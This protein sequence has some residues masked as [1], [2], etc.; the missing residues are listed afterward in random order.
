MYNLYRDKRNH[1]A[2]SSV[3]SSPTLCITITK[4]IRWMHTNWSI[5]HC[6]VLNWRMTYWNKLTGVLHLMMS[7]CCTWKRCHCC[8]LTRSHHCCPPPHPCHHPHHCP[9]RPLPSHQSHNLSSPLHVLT[10]IIVF[11][12]ILL[13]LFVIIVI[14]V[15]NIFGIIPL[16]C[17]FVGSSGGST[18]PTNLIVLV[19]SQISGR[20]TCPR[21]L[22]TTIAEHRFCRYSFCCQTLLDSRAVFTGACHDSCH[23]H[24]TKICNVMIYKLEGENGSGKELCICIPCQWHR[25]LLNDMTSQKEENSE[26]NAGRWSVTVDN[27]WVT[28]LLKENT[29][30]PGIFF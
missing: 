24:Q 27:L 30:L 16:F 17:R 4:D 13:P 1:L 9:C 6:I 18:W 22:N 8:C 25:H 5:T 28:L 7:Y 14:V 15:L 12:V 11:A 2:S 19:L 20:L 26:W 3:L 29:N 23:G 21:W 10:A